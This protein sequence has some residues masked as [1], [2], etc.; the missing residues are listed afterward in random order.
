MPQRRIVIDTREQRP[1]RF[2]GMASVVGTLATGD[3]SLEGFEGAVAVE[4]KTKT[5]AYSCV[6]NSR[7][8]FVRCLSRL[9]E[10]DRG[11]VIIEADLQDFAVPPP[12]T[13]V[14]AASAVGSYVSW[15]C[16]FGIPVMFCGSREFAERVTIR[17][18]E[19]YEKYRTER[20]Q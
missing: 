18:L 19:S 9:A 7:Q 8:R 11:I 13:K 6:G 4:R 17:F 14:G 20:G 5:D 10:L 16:R 1:Y 12:Y 2:K 15:V 3:Y